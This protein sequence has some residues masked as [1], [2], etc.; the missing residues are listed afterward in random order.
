MQIISNVSY[1]LG[2]LDK[3]NSTNINFY[4]VAFSGYFPNKVLQIARLAQLFQ[5]NTTKRW[6]LFLVCNGKRVL[7]SISVIWEFHRS[8]SPQQLHLQIFFFF[9][10]IIT[11]DIFYDVPY[12]HSAIR[13]THKSDE[14]HIKDR[15]RASSNGD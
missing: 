14:S 11:T 13:N 8:F 7:I 3:E 12:A 5:D 2:R 1:Y 4:F 9:D 15:S 6:N 10:S